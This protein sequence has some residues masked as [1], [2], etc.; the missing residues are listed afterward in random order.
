MSGPGRLNFAVLL[1]NV[2]CPINTTNTTSSA[3]PAD[4][5][6]NAL[7]IS[8]LVD[9]AVARFGSASGLSVR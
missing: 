6:S 1:L 2:P 5:F 9:R 8:S 4:S 7:R 3:A